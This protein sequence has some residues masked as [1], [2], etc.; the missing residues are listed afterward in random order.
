MR[1]M[2]D[3]EI[4]RIFSKAENLLKS[5]IAQDDL[6]TKK[7]VIEEPI[8]VLG[9]DDALSSWFVGVTVDD[10]IVGFMQFDSDSTFIRYSTFQRHPSSLDGCPLAEHWLDSEYIMSK[11][12]D[13][14]K[15]HEA[16]SAPFLSYDKH[17]TRLVW[18]V[19]VEGRN[20]KLKTVCVAGEYVYEYVDD[21]V[22]KI[23]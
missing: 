3:N 5:G 11:V 22:R 4:Q 9:V 21:D 2:S 23:G 17:P 20:G 18:M 19:R 8:P 7:G 6:V 16:I 14:T 13:W 1:Y 15:P 10:F 12:K